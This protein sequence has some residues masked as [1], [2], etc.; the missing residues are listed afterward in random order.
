VNPLTTTTTVNCR[1]INGFCRNISLALAIV[2][3]LLSAAT[4]AHAQ[5]T[6]IYSY[7]PSPDG[8][9]PVASLVL[10][11]KGNLYGTTLDGGA[12]RFGTVFKITPGGVETVLH[13]FPADSL[14]GA[15]PEA[16]LVMD[17]NGNLYGTTSSGGAHGV[18]TVFEVTS[19]GTETVLYSFTGGPDG[20]IPYGGLVLD[21][22][23]NLYGTTRSG[24][25]YHGGT[26]F[27]L[28]PSG[29]ETV[30]H[31]FGHGSDGKFPYAGL[32]RDSSGN[33][34]GTT[35]N[36][37]TAG[38]G[39]VFQ[40]TASG[41][42]TVL[43]SF[44]GTSGG[45]GAYPNATLIRDAAGNLYGTTVGGSPGASIAFEISAS[46]KETVLYS[47]PATDHAYGGL[48]MDSTGNLYGTT[49]FGGT[50]KV[51]GV[52]E[53]TV[54]GAV[55]TLYSFVKSQRDGYNPMAGLVMDKSGALYGT[56]FRGGSH[57][58]GA[59]FKLVP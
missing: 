10:D 24:G 18:G 31:S 49:K 30:W 23:G 6:L 48:I 52:Y 55:P 44:T 47:F 43:H 38:L 58:N 39:T 25:A 57:S 33:L 15:L 50:H 17:S 54:N 35:Y 20:G 12:D 3:L 2:L 7:G 53:I 27:E 4:P 13:S 59:V 26:A 51:G 29:A 45:D 36:G 1:N 40:I 9:S 32:V 34:Y 46:G 21:S 14:D 8:A 19:T 11:S 22:G 41:T 28:T 56:T 5:E 37:G 42:E 16:G